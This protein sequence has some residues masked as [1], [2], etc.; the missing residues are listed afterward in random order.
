MIKQGVSGN[1][2][3]L[4]S[5]T[6]DFCNGPSELQA[7]SDSEISVVPSRTNRMIA[8]RKYAVNAL[9]ADGYRH[10][11]RTNAMLGVA[12]II[13]V[14]GRQQREVDGTMVVLRDSE[15]L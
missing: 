6:Q 1:R 15:L 7:M 3:S 2:N 9:S 11:A 8:R 10:F 14:D 5:G 13:N 4:L 12:G